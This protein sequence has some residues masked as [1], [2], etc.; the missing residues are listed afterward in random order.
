MPG[1]EFSLGGR[2]HAPVW[3]GHLLIEH[4]VSLPVRLDL[5][6]VFSFALFDLAV[7]GLLVCKVVGYRSIN[8]LQG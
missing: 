7:H 8:L 5:A 6:F 2:F 3:I 4:R 1:T